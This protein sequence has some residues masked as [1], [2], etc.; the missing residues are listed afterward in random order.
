M[1]E[2]L[3]L[4]LL[5]LVTSDS[6]NFPAPGHLSHVHLP[7]I[8]QRL[9]AEDNNPPQPLQEPLTRNNAATE[10]QGK[11]KR[12]AIAAKDEPSTD[13]SDKIRNTDD[14]RKIREANEEDEDF[15][16]YFGDCSEDEFNSWFYGEYD[17]DCRYKVNNRTSESQM[18]L[19]YCDGECGPPLLQ[20]LESC[21]ETA[22]TYADYYRG[23][24]YKNEE[25]VPCALYFLADTYLQGAYYVEENCDLPF[26][27]GTEC[28]FDC[29][30]SVL[31]LKYELGCCVNNIYNH[32]V[33]SDLAD[34][35]LWQTCN[36]DT[37]GVCGGAT[38][39]SS[40]VLSLHLVAFLLITVLF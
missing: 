13:I 21:G 27:N 22:A 29:Y 17:Q 37:P 25:G 26:Q 9:H 16:G 7:S 3:L 30:V 6:S 23:L 18:Y 32:S 15:G 14:R 35:R 8:R 2:H 4:L 31:E 39:V 10:E 40:L 24:C 20:F 34:Y 5:C 28:T 11:H 36:V 12:N 1:T 33:P 38:A 19:I